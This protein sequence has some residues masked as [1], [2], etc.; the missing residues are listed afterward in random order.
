MI[1]NPY[2]NPPE[3]KEVPQAL[4][5]ERERI[6]ENITDLKG[7]LIDLKDYEDEITTVKDWM[8]K[9]EKYLND[10]GMGHGYI[11][12]LS[13]YKLAIDDLGEALETQSALLEEVNECIERGDTEWD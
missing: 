1:E 9:V 8:D 7:Y 6:E 10:L 3:E 11:N 12:I 5:D 2:I 4:L 13:A